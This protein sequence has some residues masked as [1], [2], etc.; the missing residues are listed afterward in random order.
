MLTMKVLCE[1]CE[2]I[3]PETFGGLYHGHLLAWGWITMRS[4]RQENS[5][6]M[7][8]LDSAEDWCMVGEDLVAAAEKVVES[9]GI[10]PAR[11]LFPSLS[12]GFV[13]FCVC[14]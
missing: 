6:M 13:G 9:L 12:S 7:P 3:E 10:G 2:G 14:V 4:F 8:C 11:S 5:T 1:R